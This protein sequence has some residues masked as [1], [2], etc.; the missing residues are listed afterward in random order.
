MV[1]NQGGVSNRT[2]IDGIKIFQNF[3]LVLWHH[4][5]MLHLVVR[6]LLLVERECT[7]DHLCSIQNVT[8]SW[9]HFFDNDIYWD[10]CNYVLVHACLQF[11]KKLSRK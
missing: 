7:Q 2:Q 8:A 9:N 6:R 10:D 3:T 1:R 4:H 5:S 11:G